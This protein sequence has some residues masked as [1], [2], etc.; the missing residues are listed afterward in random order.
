MLDD[1]LIASITAI[2]HQAGDAIMTIY[3]RDFAIY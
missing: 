3:Q 2:A 1:K